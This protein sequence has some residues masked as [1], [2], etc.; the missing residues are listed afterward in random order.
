MDEREGNEL[1]KKLDQYEKVISRID[2]RIK[3]LQK[4]RKAVTLD[5]MV[6]IVRA[7]EIPAEPTGTPYDIMSKIP[8]L[9]KETIEVLKNCDLTPEEEVENG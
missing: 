5:M 8:V 9:D 3:V 1:S 4:K 2:Y 7:N 6:E